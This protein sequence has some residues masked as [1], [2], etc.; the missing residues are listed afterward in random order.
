FCSLEYTAAPGAVS[1][2][3]H[4]ALPIFSDD[5]LVQPGQLQPFSNTLFP[6]QFPLFCSLV[7]AASLPLLALPPGPLQL[8]RMAPLQVS[9]AI[10][11]EEHT[12]ELQS[13]ENLVCRLLLEKK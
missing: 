5:L 1:L 7:P 9:V 2:S 12:S 13:R 10:R 6:C 8:S 4:D 11:S 3:L